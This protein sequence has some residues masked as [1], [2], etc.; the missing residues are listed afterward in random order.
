MA[1]YDGEI[2]IN[3]KIDTRSASGQLQRL[4]QSILKVCDKADALKEKM[5]ALANQK[6]PTEEY[7]EVSKWLEKNRAKQSALNERMEKFIELGGDRKSNVFRSMQYD[8]AQLENTIA[9]AKRELKE[10]E[11]SGTAFIDPKTTEEYKKLEAQFQSCKERAKEYAQQWDEIAKKQKK[12]GSGAKEIEKTGQA[13][14]KAGSLFGSMTRRIIGL[15][16]RVFVFSLIA[17]GLRSMV[18]G[19]K[20]GLQN[21]ARYSD[22]FNA[23]VSSFKSAS[24]TLSNAL[25][26]AAA[27]IVSTLLPWLTKL[28]DWLTYAANM[29]SKFVAIVQGKSTWTRAKKQ[30]VDYAASLDNTAKAAKEVSDNV[31]SSL[32]ELNVVNDTST[33]GS[34]SGGKTNGADMF[35]EV[36]ITDED[37][38]WAENIKDT[39][40][41]ILPLVIAIAVGLALWNITKF[42]KNLGKVLSMLSSNKTL[43]GILLIVLG[44]G[45]MVGA[46]KDIAENGVNLKNMA[47]L[48][49]SV[50][51]VVI[52]IFILFGATVAAVAAAVLLPLSLIVAG[53]VDIVN[54]GINLKNG[55]L[56][57]AG[58][59]MGVATTLGTAAAAVA[60]AIAAVVLAIIAD[61]E[62]VK[63]AV[64]EPLRQW[65]SVLKEDFDQMVGGF[66]KTI[67]GIVEFVKGVFS[68]DW[69]RAWEGVKDIFSGIWDSIT[70]VFKTAINGIIGFLNTMYGGIRGI[71]NAIIS[72]INKIDF[73]FPDWFPIFGGKHIGGFNISKMPEKSIPYL[74]DGAV[75]PP[76]SPFL[77]MLGDQKN[78]MNIETPLETMLQAFQMALE[79]K[80]YGNLVPYLQQIAN[81][82]LETAN[83]DFSFNIGDREI[84]RSAARG[85][86]SMG[87]TIIRT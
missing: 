21:F 15:I 40:E 37:I 87:M 57:V 42:V 29:F 8:A 1:E 20:E 50:L 3:T 79:E 38:A 30:Q 84:A 63:N 18:S 70:G 36:A 52:G 43:A 22:S 6:I 71:V 80:G 74:A 64:L 72:A 46:L 14:K 49:G 65:F 35:E 53:I 85:Q 51:A 39:L 60:A 17:A 55:L 78:G 47:V 75:I 11:Q 56:I 12:V 34:T 68:G 58:V 45:M 61:W 19:M 69:K 54:H 10:M 44:L 76:N 5:K 26:A 48:I 33:S 82:T 62:N 25:G 66:K 13:A 2:R 32:D 86:R 73:K 16:K 24:A 27:P 77:A 9:E 59:F 83:K 28:C 4:E 31:M 23:T 67:H 41:K 7:K 81:N